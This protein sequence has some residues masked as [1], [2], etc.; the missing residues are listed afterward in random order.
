VHQPGRGSH[1]IQLVAP[2][3]DTFGD[4]SLFDDNSVGDE[5]IP[6]LYIESRVSDAR[7]A[8]P[9]RLVPSNS[10]LAVVCNRGYGPN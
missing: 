7:G 2:D 4:D 10:A 8:S 6:V 9:R 5:F 3:V 1:A